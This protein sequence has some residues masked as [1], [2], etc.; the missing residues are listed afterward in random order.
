MNPNRVFLHAGWNR[1]RRLVMDAY[2]L[3]SA[4]GTPQTIVLLGVAGS[5]KTLLL[6]RLSQLTA[7]TGHAVRCVDGAMPADLAPTEV[8]L[9]D[10]AERLDDQALLAQSAAPRCF[11]V[12]AADSDSGHRLTALATGWQ[13]ITLNPLR[14]RELRAFVAFQLARIGAAAPTLSDDSITDI[15]TRSG[16]IPG[17]L[18]ELLAAAVAPLTGVAREPVVPDPGQ[19]AAPPHNSEPHAAA[20]IVPPSTRPSESK[21]A[22]APTLARAPP[23]DAPPAAFNAVADPSSRYVSPALGAT[24]LHPSDLLPMAAFG[25]VAATDPPPER[26]P[27][28]DSRHWR[29]WPAIAAA[30]ALVIAAGAVSITHYASRQPLIGPGSTRRLNAEMQRASAR[31]AIRSPV[32]T[33]DHPSASQAP[34]L[35]NAPLPAWQHA[36]TPLLQPAP[37]NLAVAPATVVP[38]PEPEPPLAAL[39]APPPTLQPPPPAEFPTRAPGLILVARAGDTLSDLYRKVYGD[40]PAPP[41]AVMLA[42]NPDQIKPGSRIIF[43]PPPQGWR[44]P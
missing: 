38:P 10:R 15:V 40:A 8:L 7:A 9:V 23:P 28:S 3:W 37:V 36:E 34:K 30:I 31:L 24:M 21:P 29:R 13:V 19:L 20:P 39:S 11:C 18:I 12:L 32:P 44:L 4:S 16:G 6:Q 1:A 33:P 25:T 43:P 17:R 5:G 35:P 42:A 27:D 26:L 22:P 41:F 2:A 14:P